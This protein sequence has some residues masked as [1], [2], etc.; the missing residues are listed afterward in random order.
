V[1]ESGRVRHVNE[2]VRSADWIETERVLHDLELNSLISRSG[3]TT[4]CLNPQYDE[5]GWTLVTN[6]TIKTGGLVQRD[7][8]LANAISNYTRLHL[9]LTLRL[10]WCGWQ[11]RPGSDMIC[12]Q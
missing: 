12:R 5:L 1:A 3:H 11:Q 8:Y 4:T 9:C 7:A 2:L 10:F 6:F